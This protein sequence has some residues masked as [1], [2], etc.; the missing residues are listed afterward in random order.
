M[1]YIQTHWAD[2]DVITEA[3]LNN[4]EDCLEKIINVLLSANISGAAAA[5]KPT[6]SLTIT[7]P[8]GTTFPS[9]VTA[10][11]VKQV[12]IVTAQFSDGTYV[13]NPE[14][15]TAT[16]SGSTFTANFRGQSGTYTIT[17]D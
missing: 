3:K 11:Q 16:L 9:G 5:F 17:I 10:T 12:A 1:S 13:L 14:D 2:G 6:A 7:V 15:Y 8:Q 4:I